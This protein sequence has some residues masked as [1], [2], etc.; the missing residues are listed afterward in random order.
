MSA[1]N[2]V[3]GGGTPIPV[4]VVFRCF[5]LFFIVSRC[6]SV[7]RTIVVKS[8]IVSSNA[9]KNVISFFPKSLKY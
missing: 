9:K 3:L 7:N 8:V 6:F 4:G 1:I 5:S 2:H